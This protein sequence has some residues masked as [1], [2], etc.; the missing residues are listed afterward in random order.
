M[1]RLT[2][3]ARVSLSLGTLLLTTF[4][5]VSV[6]STLAAPVT[7]GVT[8]PAPTVSA[9]AHGADGTHPFFGFGLAY[10]PPNKLMNLY[11]VIAIPGSPAARK[12]MP[13][14]HWSDLVSLNGQSATTS[15]RQVT[16]LFQS[17]PRL[18]V[19]YR[20]FGDRVRKTWPAVTILLDAKATFPAPTAASRHEAALTEVRYWQGK[21]E[22]AKKSF[23]VYDRRFNSAL[24]L[25][26]PN[27][28]PQ[29]LAKARNLE[30]VIGAYDLGIQLAE[31]DRI[32][33]AG[34][35]NLRSLEGVREHIIGNETEL[36]PYL[37]EEGRL[38]PHDAVTSQYLAQVHKL[39]ILR[40]L[41]VPD[42]QSIPFVIDM[43]NRYSREVHAYIV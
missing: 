9:A 37:A 32:A 20:N 24:R 16:A 38:F 41:R 15:P 30:I 31:Q 14:S 22:K 21:L 35:K 28:D 19:T 26:L 7:A 43:N 3:T 42:I 6:S 39:A 36:K 23:A 34:T 27:A 4:V 12:G 25:A 18:R 2:S 17:S 11:R 29:T 5:S 40:Q 33:W 13:T 10:S 8:E 1:P